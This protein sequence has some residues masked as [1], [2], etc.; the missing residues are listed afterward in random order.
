ME[1]IVRNGVAALPG[2]EGSTR[3]RGQ[4]NALSECS[5]GSVVVGPMARQPA[6]SRR[7]HR[8]CQ[9][10][11]AYHHLC[12]RHVPH[13]RPRHAAGP[14][15]AGADR[16]TEP[17]RS[18]CPRRQVRCERHTDGMRRLRLRPSAQYGSAR[19]SWAVRPPRCRCHFAANRRIEE[20]GFPFLRRRPAIAGTG[21]DAPDRSSPLIYISDSC[22][23]SRTT[24]TVIRHREA[25]CGAKE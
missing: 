8:E 1:V 13:T 2:G 12:R 3:G 10:R 23:R 5:G 9:V 17:R 19:R 24:G 11:R 14:S 20:S 4:S 6:I 15:I 16:Y 18:S 21:D 7:P 22:S 25:T